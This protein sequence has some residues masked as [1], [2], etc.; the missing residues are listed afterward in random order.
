MVFLLSWYLT[1]NVSY[2]EFP[3]E[4]HLDRRRQ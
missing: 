1:L 3:S 2:L 4:D